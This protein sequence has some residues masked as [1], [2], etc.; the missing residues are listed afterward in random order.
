MSHSAEHLSRPHSWRPHLVKQAVRRQ[1]GSW[2]SSTNA[3]GSTRNSTHNHIINDETTHLPT[4]TC[5]YVVCRAIKCSGYHTASIVLV[6]LQGR[7]VGAATVRWESVYKHAAGRC[8]TRGGLRL[9]CWLL[10]GT[11]DGGRSV[12][13]G[14]LDWSGYLSRLWM[15]TVFIVC[16]L[17]A[18]R[19]PDKASGKISFKVILG[20]VFNCGHVHNARHVVWN[21]HS[22]LLA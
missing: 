4:S 19:F 1:A 16:I 8:S 21:V 12:K 5:M 11:W 17:V 22:C 14:L 10:L 18:L 20:D 2:I 6:E 9:G 13:A 15:V 3:P 7:L